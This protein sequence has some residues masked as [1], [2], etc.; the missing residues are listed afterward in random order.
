MLLFAALFGAM[1]LA[2][3]VSR[4]PVTTWL[5]AAPSGWV[6]A[7]LVPGDQVTVNGSEVRSARVRLNILRGCE[8]TEAFFLLAAGMLAFPG[9]WR[10]KAFGL[11]VGLPLV[12]ALNQVR[13]VA[14]YFT[15][16]DFPR[17][18][19]LMHGYVAP[20]V[21]VACVAVVF[22]LWT[23]RSAPAHAAA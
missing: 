10:A 22:W 14:L 3:I 21:L 4:A 5:A 7:R 9:R 15:V 12:F 17:Q 11:A 20:T 23:S 8:G 2:L 1:Q 19:A 6:L 13:I 18:F 16:R